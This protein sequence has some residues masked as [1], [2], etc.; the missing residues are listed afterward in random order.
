MT[1]ENYPVLFLDIDGVLNSDQT[2]ALFGGYPHSF[3]PDDMERFDPLAIGLIRRLCS[4]TGARCV[5]SSDW[6]YT[7][8]VEQCA[9]ALDLPIF[10]ETPGGNDFPSRGHEI[11]AWLRDNPQITHYA[12]VD[13]CGPMLPN[14]RPHF[15]CTDDALGLTLADFKRLRDIL[16]KGPRL[17]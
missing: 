12:I 9:E 5:L 4:D 16:T 17:S 15:V 10:S 1:A 2:A 11:A 13:D 14:Q 7:Y 3:S 8:T 6:R